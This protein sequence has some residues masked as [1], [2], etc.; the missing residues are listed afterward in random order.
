MGPRAGPRGDEPPHAG[1]CAPFKAFTAGMGGLAL[2]WYWGLG[3]GWHAEG[4]QRNHQ[5]LDMAGA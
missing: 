1:A 2:S 5:G 3:S 4:M